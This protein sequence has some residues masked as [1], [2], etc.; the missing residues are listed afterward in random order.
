MAT[1]IDV[2]NLLTFV[3]SCIVPT[4]DFRAQQP[5][6]I[7]LSD[8]KYQKYRHFFSGTLDDVKAAW[9][10]L[11]KGRANDK[12]LL[13][14][15]RRKYKE[16]GSHTQ[17]NSKSKQLQANTMNSYG[18]DP[19]DDHIVNG[20][21]K[22]FAQMFG[23]G[24]NKEEFI[25]YFDEYKSSENEDISHVF[26][27]IM[28]L[29]SG[30]LNCLHFV[31]FMT[32]VYEAPQLQK[33]Q[34]FMSRAC[35]VKAEENKLYSVSKCGKGQMNGNDGDLD[36]FAN[37]NQTQQKQS[38]NATD[39]IMGIMADHVTQ[40]DTVKESKRKKEN[41]AFLDMVAN[42]TNVAQNNDDG[43]I[44][45]IMKTAAN[46]QQNAAAASGSSAF[47]F[48]LSG[49]NAQTQTQNVNAQA[50]AG[51]GGASVFVFEL[52]GG[53]AQQ[54][55]GVQQQTEAQPKAS[56]GGGST[57]GVDCVS[58]GGGGIAP[59][60]TNNA[61]RMTQQMMNPMMTP[62]MMQQ[63]QQS[64]Q[65]KDNDTEKDE[66]IEMIELDVALAYD[67][68]ALE[69]K[70]KQQ[71][72]KIKRQTKEIKRLKKLVKSLTFIHPIGSRVL[73]K[74]TN[75]S[76]NQWGTVDSYT[77]NVRFTGIGYDHIASLSPEQLI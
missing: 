39:G 58:S 59:T 54:T 61:N 26:N 23:N 60:S 14:L 8:E 31:E 24:V 7:V 48:D 1:D 5:I 46:T 6:K 19:S 13:L 18:D 43:D 65:F 76:T 40:D 74:S 72:N 66:P 28:C 22:S 75:K 71:N 21:V 73:V 55:Q 47:G 29:S 20:F 11:S 3:Q 30:T 69:K 25:R 64:Q 15:N 62:Q 37:M 42:D 17:S 56:T 77:A 12:F 45:G 9:N 63:S 53:A 49:D 41:Y 50:S 32:K 34:E 51:G 4:N 35:A 52:S 16:G 38:T 36:M 2:D 10:E 27:W 70:N 57:F 67:V 68:V 33:A 44:L